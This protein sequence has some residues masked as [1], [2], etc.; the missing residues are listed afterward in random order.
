M[1]RKQFKADL[2]DA[3]QG[4]YGVDSIS[5]CRLGE[6]DGQF[7]FVFTHP[8]LNLPATITA[9]VGEQSDYPHTHEYSLFCDDDASEDAAVCIDSLGKP[10]GMPIKAF[11]NLVSGALSGSSTP[12][13]SEP[14]P[15]S[16][17]PESDYESPQEQDTDDD[18]EDAFDEAFGDPVPLT[19]AAFTTFATIRAGSPTVFQSRIRRDLKFAKDAGFRVASFGGLLDNYKC[20]VS[21]SIRARRLGI[22]EAAMHAWRI[23][24]SDFIILLIQYK[25]GYKTKEELDTLQHGGALAT[26]LEIRVGAS[27]KYKPTEQQ[28]TNAFSTIVK[29]TSQ[30]ETADP[31]LFRDIFVSKPLNNLLNKELVSLIRLRDSSMSWQGAEDFSYKV[32]WGM[33]FDNAF[34]KA[35]QFEPE[36][37]SGYPAVVD[38]DHLAD[39]SIKSHSFPLIA[40]QFMLRHFVRCTEFCLVCHKKLDNLVE[41]IKPYVCDTPLCLY[42]YM[43]LGFGPSIEH[44]IMMQDKVVDLLISFCYTSAN[45]GR[46]KDFPTGLYLSVPRS[47]IS[48]VAAQAGRSPHGLVQ[49]LGA[50]PPIEGRL[51]ARFNMTKS[52]ILFDNVKPGTVCPL[53]K[54]DWIALELP[55]EA[56]SSLYHCRVANPDLFPSIEIGPLIGQPVSK[57]LS[58]TP[59]WS[60]AFIDQYSVKFDELSEAEKRGAVYRLLALLP[61]VKEMNAYLAKQ[62]TPDLARWVDRISPAAFAVLRWT[63]ASNRS[64][65]MAV[66]EPGK[67]VHGMPEYMQFRFAMGAPDKEHRFKTAVKKTAKRLD[68]KYPT[69]YAWHGSSIQNWHSIIREGLHFSD[70]VNG[71]AFGNGVYHAPNAATSMG[72]SGMGPYGYGNNSVPFIWPNS[73]LQISSAIALN[74][75]VNAP[76]EYVSSTP[77]Y[78]VAQLDWIQTRYLFVKCKP[79]DADAE[80][81]VPVF[82]KPPTSKLEQD[83]ARVPI[84]AANTP[85]IIP[86]LSSK[87]EKGKRKLANT[88]SPGPKK[89]KRAKKQDWFM[90]KIAPTRKVVDLT[91]DDDNGDVD[92]TRFEDSDLS[93][94]SSTV[95]DDEDHEI[96]K[97]P[98]SQQLAVRTGPPP[99]EF[100]PGSLDHDKLP[101]LPEPS[102]ANVM[103]TRR[104][105]QDLKVL[106]AVQKHT[107]LHELGW[108]IDP[109]KIGNM[110]QWI[111]EVHSFH[112]F[113]EGDEELPLVTDM[114]KHNVKSIV[115]EMRF[116]GSYPINPPFIRVIRPRFLPFANGGGGHVT[117]GGAI[118]H[119]LLTSDGW[120]PTN[121]IES[122]L[123]Q[124]RMAM[125][126]VEPAPARLQLRGTYAEG[127]QNSYGS[128]EAVDAYRRACKMHGWTVPS[129]FDQTIAEQ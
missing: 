61:S 73:D 56:G 109:E 29:A 68:S 99:I 126:S 63:L 70:V 34:T 58:T 102:Y 18:D 43:S 2:N 118:C 47:I 129:D 54:G 90:G 72:Y 94:A 116:P 87:P 19:S 96:F 53:K 81:P 36:P 125:A 5:G 50:Q 98:Q 104:L 107:P 44:E 42:Q 76:A 40:M 3:I 23:E 4:E 92:E 49:P 12:S 27:K 52:E 45:L 59:K 1:P 121:T 101:K 88:V 123:L 100:V 17:E 55:D 64:C 128:G 26:N 91:G 112:M 51:E 117:A 62:N 115:L 84:G 15:D 79:A 85:I 11:L 20:V 67:A 119:A 39:L 83:P 7:T 9:S 38:A 16:V 77:H 106:L 32:K 60:T 28:V 30:D 57:E 10:K 14:L 25:E 82:D 8:T 33:S 46:L 105:T 22:S 41:A 122:V 31:A 80:Q 110:Y 114:K 124:I 37:A 6:D 95:S 93:D 113:N 13:L 127:D 111:V 71:R 66:D 86:N 75:I 74:E 108:Y 69:L 35:E 48:G 24:P 97:E 103:A 120:L 78:V 65:I 21:M 89:T